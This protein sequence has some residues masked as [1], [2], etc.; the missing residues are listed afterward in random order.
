MIL[1]LAGGVL[2]LKRVFPLDE[3][4]NQRFRIAAL[5]GAVLFA[6][7]GLVDVA[8]H[9]VGSALAGVFLLGLAL[10][11]PLPLRASGVLTN[12][13]RI[14]GLLLLATGS[15]WVFAAYRE[16]PLPGGMGADLAKRRATA[17]HVGRNA[18]E[19]IAEA[20]RGLEW[21]PLDWQ[22][23]FLRA[24][25]SVGAGRSRA[26]TLADFRRARFLEPNSMEVPFQ[27]GIAWLTRQPV[28]TI[29]AWRD[30]L[31]RAGPAER[32]ELYAR[33]LRASRA[34][35]AADRMIKEFAATQP[36]LLLVFLDGAPRSDFAAAIGRLLLHDP[37]LAS[38][39]A[40]QI[41]QLFALW[42]RYGDSAQLIELMEAQP[43][44]L[45]I[46]W[47]AA[48]QAYARRQDFRNA[49]AVTRK[50]GEPSVFPQ[51]ISGLTPE[52]LQK[53]IF[54]NRDSF[55]AGY[56]LFDEQMRRGDIDGA[57]ITVRHFSEARDCPPYFH[58]LEAEAWAAKENWER[59]WTARQKLDAA[60]P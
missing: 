41:G 47:R 30:A 4:S 38:F 55:A 46:G 29:T 6:L 12:A 57:L 27:E 22:L 7:H 35:P 26:E 2:V 19:T 59:A 52:Q 32:P 60:K 54:A 5:I 39:S 48:A 43:A 37:T 16:A 42:D 9:R 45:R 34:D 40:E 13:F 20:N 56:T 25:G 33:M 36:E 21:A 50:F 31:R 51:K 18:N 58:F 44:L 23:Y 3:G 8:G 28:L 15:A 49:Y 14:L 24:L 10:R 1:I 11:R 17:A 53:E